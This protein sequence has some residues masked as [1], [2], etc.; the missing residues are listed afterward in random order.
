MMWT[1][2]IIALV[3]T[4]NSI[5]AKWNMR[6]CG[7]ASVK[8][9]VGNGGFRI[10]GGQEARPG[11]WPWQAGIR[12]TEYADYQP[13]G[14]TLIHPQWVL[15]AAHCFPSPSSQKASSWQI[16]LGKHTE[17]SYE[18]SEQKIRIE[19]IIVHPN[20]DWTKTDAD[21]TLIKLAKPARINSRV[22]TACLPNGYPMVGA[23]CYA[24][25]W[26]DTQGTSSHGNL[27]QVMVPIISERVCKRT[28][29]YGRSAIT[30]NMICAG[31]PNGRHDSCQG[32][33]GGPFVCEGDGRFEVTGVV[34][35][36][37]G[38]ASP[39]SPGVY[40]KVRNFVDWIEDTM[41]NN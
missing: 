7:V 20:Y 32:D 28:D 34:S 23:P 8:P 38:C 11:S 12:S 6:N 10:V 18:P 41:G 27:K 24:T 37:I 40:A 16:V 15:T 3:L 36:G 39:R 29:Y 14:G 1:L 19:K 31:Y 2:R 21:I 30:D 17:I 9:K 4:I 5:T 26:G 22:R 13:C 33:S 35:W 25:G